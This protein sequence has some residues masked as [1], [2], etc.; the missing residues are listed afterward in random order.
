M[1][2]NRQAAVRAFEEEC[3]RK[4]SQLEDQSSFNL[5]KH[6]TKKNENE[7]NSQAFKDHMSKNMQV[8]L[9]SKANDDFL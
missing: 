5:S 4:R 1:E 6:H 2:K 3:R 8:S 7:T 9:K